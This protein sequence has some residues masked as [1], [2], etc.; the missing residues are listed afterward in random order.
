MSR[1]TPLADNL[2]TKH[3]EKQKQSFTDF[4]LNQ[5]L[6]I[7]LDH[8]AINLSDHLNL[9]LNNGHNAWCLNSCYYND[10][11]FPNGFVSDESVRYSEGR[12]GDSI[13]RD[14]L[15]VNNDLLSW[16]RGYANEKNFSD[17][18]NSYLLQCT[19]PTKFLFFPIFDY[20]FKNNIFF[21]RFNKI[22]F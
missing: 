21:K 12:Y 6:Y 2:K 17:E 18:N 9:N 15:F 19:K 16:N 14:G 22:C 8:Q 4:S 7:N 11:S 10:Y 20:T 3:T 5:P 13:R 1:K